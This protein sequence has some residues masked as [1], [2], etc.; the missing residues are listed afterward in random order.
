MYQQQVMDSVIRSLGGE[1]RVA[2][3]IGSYRYAIEQKLPSVLSDSFEGLSSTDSRPYVLR[4][5]VASAFADQMQLSGFKVKN[6][7]FGGS[8]W[9]NCVAEGNGLSVTTCKISGPNAKLPDNQFVNSMKISNQMVLPLEE[10][11]PD[12]DDDAPLK[13]VVAYHLFRR[14]NASALGGVELV[15]PFADT[16]SEMRKDVTSFEVKKQRPQISTVVPVVR[17]KAKRS[18]VNGND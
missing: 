17:V 7:V 4:D 15:L 5:C 8:W 16:D 10:F 13:V 18:V 14:G 2:T 1:D 6:G 3:L 12:A 9:T 11:L